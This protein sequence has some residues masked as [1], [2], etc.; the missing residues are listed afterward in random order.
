MS[1][2]MGPGVTGHPLQ[3]ILSLS[4]LAQKMTMSRHV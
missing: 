2:V 3:K 4:F 1:D